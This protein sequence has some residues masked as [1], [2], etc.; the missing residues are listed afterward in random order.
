MNNIPPNGGPWFCIRCG[1]SNI[2]ASEDCSQCHTLRPIERH[3]HNPNVT[4]DYRTESQ[5]QTNVFSRNNTAQTNP[6]N[7]PGNIL[8]YIPVQQ[9]PMQSAQQQYIAIEPK[10]R[11]AY[12]LLGVFLGTLGIHNFYA[13][14]NGKGIAQ[15]LITLFGSCVFFVGPLFSAV[16]ALI[17]IIVV[18]KDANGIRMK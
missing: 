10:S 4:S 7:P 9:A 5:K 8:G 17:E 3:H 1:Y 18:D 6:L 16:W 14:H 11:V 15:L 12:I 2:M 13:G